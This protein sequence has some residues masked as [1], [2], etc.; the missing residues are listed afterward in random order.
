MRHNKVDDLPCADFAKVIG[1]SSS[2]I[3]IPDEI[4]NVTQIYSKREPGASF[5]HRRAR[6]PGII[7]EVRS[8]QEVFITS[9]QLCDFHSCAEEE[10]Q[11]QMLQQG[12]TNRLRPGDRKRPRP[13][14]PPEQP[15]LEE[16]KGESKCGRRSSDLCPNS[17]S[18]YSKGELG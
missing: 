9:R 2:R 17:S 1:H 5:K 3:E 6:Y 7:I 10:Q 15:S 11:L 14:T 18:G 16:R 12:S 8:S 13:Q 4:R